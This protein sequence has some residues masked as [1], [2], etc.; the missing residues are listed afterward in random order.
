MCGGGEVHSSM[1]VW[2]MCDFVREGLY[3]GYVNVYVWYV[4]C[5]CVCEN[6]LCI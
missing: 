5:V 2:Y 4:V 1:C 6:V 3:V